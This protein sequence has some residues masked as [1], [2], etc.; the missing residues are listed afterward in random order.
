MADNWYYVQ[1]GNRH[2]PVAIEV[3]E[4]MLKGGQLEGD[5]FVWKKGFENWKKIK[6]VTELQPQASVVEAPSAP[7]QIPKAAEVKTTPFIAPVPKAEARPEPK[8]DPIPVP[9][10]EAKPE[11]RQ[12][13]KI[14][15][16]PEPKFAPKVQVEV[17]QEKPFSLRDLHLEDRVIFLRIGSDRGGASSDYGPY[18]LKQLKQLF[19][20]KRINGKTYLFSKG[21]QEWSLLADFPEYQEIFEELP[22]VIGEA[23]RRTA[24]RKPFVARL[25]VQN[26][27]IVFEGLCRDI[28]IGG[29]QVLIDKFGG[30]AG[31]K[32]TINVHPEN[33]E[34][35]FTASGV[36]VRILEGN[37]GFSFRFHGLSDE[38][39]R[40]I[41]K[42]VQE[43]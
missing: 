5:D 24:I 26:N 20:E 2:G 43:N 19:K 8:P 17:P 12:P 31:D 11:V 23:E 27:K 1:K 35:H 34:Y 10:V 40:A 6:E 42:Y 21:M 18:S 29:M 32:I 16:K 38:A 22:P 3:I 14:E 13:P 36:V 7:V 33:T 39:R 4:T 30:N 15:A 28:S 9:M 37:S 25:F 41:E